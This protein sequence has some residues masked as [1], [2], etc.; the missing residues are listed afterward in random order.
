MVYVFLGH[1]IDWVVAITSCAI[2]FFICGVF[3]WITYRPKKLKMFIGIRQGLRESYNHL[4]EAGKTLKILDETLQEVE[5][6][7]PR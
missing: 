1:E 5:K 7:A 3:F 2:G 4:L 6:N